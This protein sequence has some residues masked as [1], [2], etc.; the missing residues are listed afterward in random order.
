MKYK[1]LVLDRLLDRYEKSKSF[2]DGN[3]KRRIM[4][5][6][7][8]GDFPEYDIEKPLIRETFNSVVEELAG[9]GLVGFDWLKHEKGN[10]IEKVWLNVS[11][12]EDCYAEIVRK[13]RRIVLDALLS[14]AIDIKDKAKGGWIAEFLEEIEQSIK[15]KAS[16][17]GLLPTDEE[18]ALAILA[19]LDSLRK[20][21]GGQCLERV[22]SLRCFNDS[23]YFEKKVRN[24]LVG[25]IKRYCLEQELTDEM[26]DDEVLMQVGILQ[27]PEQVDFKGGICGAVNGR[28][29]DFTAFIHGISLNVDTIK[30]L[31][32]EGMGNVRKILFIE[33][34]ANYIHF[35]AENKD[36]TLMTVFHGGFYSPAKG[37]FFR[38]LY[39]TAF[40]HGVE[41][42]HWG[43]MDLG[44]FMIFKRL[45]TNIIPTLKPYLMDR[46]AFESRMEYGVEFDLKYAEK[47]KML[48]EDEQFYEFKDV[49][50]LMLEKGIKLEQEAFLI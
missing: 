25:I 20:L 6:M 34:K 37:I 11:R 30:D 18:Q 14:R 27:S 36:N 7:T 29:I 39:E 16:T 41:F 49:I 10:I 42:Y 9:K 17:A 15:E 22:F 43:D 31:V 8:K 3:S 13:A 2:I 28:K 47:L 44:G 45:K 21:E 38:K 23:K 46:K 24:R 26:S 40:P 5:K 33:N 1:K 4:L 50:K 12:V 19:A 48:L 32:I 35:L